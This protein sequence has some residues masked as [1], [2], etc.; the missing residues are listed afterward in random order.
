MILLKTLLLVLLLGLGACSDEATRLAY[1]IESAALKLEA[2]DKNSTEITHTPWAYPDGV[3]GD[4]KV[5]LYP[6]ALV[7]HQREPESFKNRSL[8]IHRYSTSFHCRFVSVSE[9]LQVEKNADG[10][11]YLLLQKTNKPWNYTSGGKTFKGINTI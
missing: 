4:Y 1:D 9:F 3:K 2:S 6:T 5:S 7:P 8:R 10:P 11:T